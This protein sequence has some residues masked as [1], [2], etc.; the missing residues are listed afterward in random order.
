MNF[1]YGGI[2]FFFGKIKVNSEG[3]ENKY[4]SIYSTNPMH[5]S[6]Q[7][8]AKFDKLWHKLQVYLA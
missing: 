4:R 5:Y 1:P 8:K 3:K 7:A 6:P 2:E